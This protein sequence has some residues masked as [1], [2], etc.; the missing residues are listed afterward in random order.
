MTLRLRILFLVLVASLGVAVAPAIA[1]DL[2]D[3]LDRV[4]DRIG[5][6]NRQINDATAERSELAARVR[7]TN[8]EMEEVAASREAVRN[9]VEGLEAAIADE[10]QQLEQL[11]GSLADQNRQLA[12]TRSDLSSARDSA[13][14]WAQQAYMNAG[15]SAP[16]VAFSASAVSDLALVV[17]YL[18]RITADSEASISD[19]EALVQQ[20][21]RARLVIVEAQSEVSARL[22]DL[23]EDA[24]R[25][26]SLQELLT[27]REEELLERV[28]E[29]EGLLA[30]VEWE[31]DN[32][33]GQ[34]A[35]LEREESSIRKLIAG[36]TSSSGRAP[37][38]LIRPVPGPLDSSFGPRVHPIHGTVR[39]HNGLDLDGATG[40]PIVAAGAGTVILA[41][42]KGGYGQTVMID[43][44]GG[45][46]TLYAHQSKLAVSVGQKVAAGE[47]IGSVGSTGV[48]TGPHLHFEVRINGDPVN[49]A[50][51]L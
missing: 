27:L 49:P 36:K 6:L 35:A 18:G 25:L 9:D 16:A 38:R 47:R 11:Q 33:E 32:W 14:H 23:G 7:Q 10:Q 29:Q 34:L 4:R 17:E 51:Y 46:V 21:A 39:M 20:E 22:A 8:A 43:H 2:D 3:N 12:V 45:M 50:G 42:T 30:E 26:A 1:G 28:E 44:G 13:V 48:S 40:E 5:S 37:G 41:G 19:Y 15:Q 24:A 31:V